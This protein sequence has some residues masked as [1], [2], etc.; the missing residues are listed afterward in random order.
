M[1]NNTELAL[2]AS[3]WGHSAESVCPVAVP[4]ENGTHPAAEDGPFAWPESVQG[5]VLGSYFWGYIFTQLPGGRIAE[6]FSAKWVIWMAVF[7]N[8]L[9][10]VITPDSAYLSYYALLTV[11]FIE[12]LAAVSYSMVSPIQ[13]TKMTFF[14]REQ[15]VSLPAI[16]VMLSKWAPAEERNRISS[17]AYAGFPASINSPDCRI[18][19]TIVFLSRNGCWD[20][21]QPAVFWIPS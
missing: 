20:C 16:H 19:A 5:I 12:G 6:M 7:V 18:T 17:L 11:R 14:I 9:M 21:H 10:T 15:G 1:I 2:E 4:S 8:G 3:H 13:E